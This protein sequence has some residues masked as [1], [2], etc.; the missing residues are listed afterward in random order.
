MSQDDYNTVLY[1]NTNCIYS[2]NHTENSNDDITVAQFRGKKYNKWM[3]I[4]DSSSFATTHYALLVASV[5]SLYPFFCM[6]ITGYKGDNNSNMSSN[7][8][9]NNV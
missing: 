3:R 1:H 4:G 7:N 2:F 5:P 6:R 8:N 9:S